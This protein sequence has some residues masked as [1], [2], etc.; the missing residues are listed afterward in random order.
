MPILSVTCT[1]PTAQ[2]VTDPGSS[3]FTMTIPPG[4]TRTE[5]VPDDIAA[6]IKPVLERMRVTGK[7]T[8]NVVFYPPDTSFEGALVAP[9]AGLPSQ[10]GHAGQVLMTD[11]TNLF[12]ASAGSPPFH[13]PLVLLDDGA[14]NPMLQALDAFT[15]SARTLLPI[16][17]A[18][19]GSGGSPW[20][21]IHLAVADNFT[22]RATV[23]MDPFTSTL[24]FGTAADGQAVQL[25]L[26]GQG[27]TPRL[28]VLRD[29]GSGLSTSWE[30]TPLG[31]SFAT[32]NKA[33][34][35]TTVGAAG[36][37]AA[38]PGDP[39]GYLKFVL[40]DGIAPSLVAVPFWPA[41]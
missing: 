29:Q 30:W 33:N 26:S 10:S 15:V 39:A 23:D 16:G 8:W 6:R 19:L 36:G 41:S 22:G 25:Q 9:G 1:A 24:L 32:W 34:S 27:G 40:D 17:T 7:I 38:L 37:A 31:V 13:A 35:Q 3:S 11:G 18:E 2:V 28:T 14:G 20:A 5:F 12:W 21:G 4:Q